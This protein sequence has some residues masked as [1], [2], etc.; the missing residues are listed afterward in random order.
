MHTLC[1]LVMNTSQVKWYIGNA[2][3]VQYAPGAYKSLFILC[4]IIMC[5]PNNISRKKRYGKKEKHT[6]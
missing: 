2:D 3:T 1:S 6:M 4:I 5:L